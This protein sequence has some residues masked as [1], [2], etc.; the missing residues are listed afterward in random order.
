MEHK[1][2]VQGLEMLNKQH[3]LPRHLLAVQWA[4]VLGKPKKAWVGRPALAF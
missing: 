1:S 2:G 3:R 4:A